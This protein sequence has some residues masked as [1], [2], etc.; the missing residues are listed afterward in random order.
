MKK[1]VYTYKTSLL[2]INYYHIFIKL[3]QKGERVYYE[4]LCGKYFEPIKYKL[5][6]RIPKRDGISLDFC[7][8]C[9]NKLIN[10]Y[11]QERKENNV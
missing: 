7:P 8:S 9:F 1:F 5:T 6:N 2:T 4:T 10:N 11:F 3:C